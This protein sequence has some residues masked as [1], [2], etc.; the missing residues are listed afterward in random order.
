MLYNDNPGI[1]A[2][3]GIIICYSRDMVHAV[4][5]TLTRPTVQYGFLT[6]RQGKLSHLG[7]GAIPYAVF[8]RERER[9]R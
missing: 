3:L 8:E 7:L 4:M 6:V 2:S 9:Q 5:L 1:H